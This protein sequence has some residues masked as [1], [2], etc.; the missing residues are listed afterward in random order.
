MYGNR[1]QD[2]LLAELRPGRTGNQ[3]LA[4]TLAAMRAAGIEGTI[5]SHPVG[6]HGHGAG[7]LIG[8]WDRQEG[9]P[10]RGDLA[11]R[12]ATW[13]SIELQATSPIPEWGGRRLACRQE[14]E[15]YLD[16]TG[17]R[18]WTFRRQERFHLVR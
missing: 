16:A 8:L 7:P 1:V 9:V 18:H 2:I 15:A 17:E 5:Y 12:P 6:D 11:V 3:V 14:E 4:A 10:V 13:F